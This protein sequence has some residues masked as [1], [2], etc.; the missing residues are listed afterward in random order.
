MEGVGSR[1]LW[2]SGSED[3]AG[4]MTRI[5][6]FKRLVISPTYGNCGPGDVVRGCSDAFARHC[7]EELK[8][9]EYMDAPDRSSSPTGRDLAGFT[10]VRR[11]R[12]G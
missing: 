4:I 1:P 9:A 8:A 2:F 6:K 7:V 10:R 12:R 11:V 3:G 5:I